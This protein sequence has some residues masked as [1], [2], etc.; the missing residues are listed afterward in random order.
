[1]KI[2]R[3]WCVTQYSSCVSIK[4]CQKLGKFKSKSKK[5]AL[6]IA[7]Y[8]GS[9][10]DGSADTSYLFMPSTVSLFFHWDSQY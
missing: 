2:D 3:K 6:G 4:S 10:V 9:Y 5:G 7:E 1:V 8:T